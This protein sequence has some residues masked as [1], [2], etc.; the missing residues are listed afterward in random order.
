MTLDL[1]SGG[2]ILLGVSIVRRDAVTPYF[3]DLRSKGRLSWPVLLH[4][5]QCVLRAR[6]YC[7]PYK[8]NIVI[9][10]AG[11]PIIVYYDRHVINICIHYQLVNYS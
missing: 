10:V 1:V 5:I 9:N 3:D 2:Y 8:P 11:I 6:L 4:L 7:W